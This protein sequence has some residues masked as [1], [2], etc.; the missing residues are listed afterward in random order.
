MRSKSSTIELSAGGNRAEPIPLGASISDFPE[1]RQRRMADIAQAFAF[2]DSSSNELPVLRHV[3]AVSQGL[4][5]P[6]EIIHVFPEKNVGMGP[7]D[8]IQ[9]QIECRE[10]Q[11]HLRKI[12]EA[13]CG[14]SLQQEQFPLVQ[15]AGDAVSRWA[16]DHVGS[17]VAVASRSGGWTTASPGFGHDKSLGGI[18]QTLLENGNTSLLLVPPDVPEIQVV[19]YQR[20]LVPLDGSCRAESILPFALRIARAHEAELVLAIVVPKPEIVVANQH[21]KQAQD[22]RAQM[23]RYSKQSAHV[24]LDRLQTRLGREA[25]AIRTIIECEGDPRDR[26]LKIS[27][28]VEA[29]LIVMSARGRSGMNN[30]SCGTI[31]RHVATHARIPLLMI[32]QQ[33]SFQSDPYRVPDQASRPLFWESAH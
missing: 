29:D 17:L 11:D 10:V 6:F 30:L 18:A 25:V 26:L 21:D 31:A 32:R 4:D 23:L 13:E 28:E 22:L 2:L 1:V 9:W 7:R 27:D 3:R 12:L 5:I 8:P 20:I 15:I 33:T 14:D 24:Y 19:R 16:V